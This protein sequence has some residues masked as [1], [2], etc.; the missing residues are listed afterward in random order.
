MHRLLRRLGAALVLAV[1][2][3]GVAGGTETAIQI[4]TA[5]FHATPDV[6]DFVLAIAKPTATAQVR[7][8]K[9]RRAVTIGRNPQGELVVTS[10]Q[11]LGKGQQPEFPDGTVAILIVHVPSEC[12]PPYGDDAQG[13]MKRIYTFVADST[14]GSVWEIGYV[15]GRGSFHLVKARDDLGPEEAFNIDPKSYKTYP[16][17]G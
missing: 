5:P 3:S 12:Q 10:L 2:V 13:L 17:T 15:G 6:Y 1:G 8:G 11:L 16:C 14:G 7:G 4:G 9:A